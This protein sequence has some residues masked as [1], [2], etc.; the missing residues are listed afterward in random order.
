VLEKV[1]S[2]ILDK[3]I[4]VDSKNAPKQLHLILISDHPEWKL[5]E[6]RV[7][8]YL[9]RLLKSRNDHRHEDIDADLDEASIYS[10]TYSAASNAS[11]TSWRKEVKSVVEAPVVSVSKEDLKSSTSPSETTAPVPLPAPMKEEIMDTISAYK[12][13]NKSEKGGKSLCCEGCMIS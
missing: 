6:R 3:S 9:K 13:E 2:D 4:N 10:E 5:P 12:D 1:M 11:G 7:A 8:K